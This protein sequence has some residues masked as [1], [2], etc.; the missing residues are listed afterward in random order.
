M[1]KNKS[2]NG[3]KKNSISK[4]FGSKSNIFNNNNSKTANFM[5]GKSLSKPFKNK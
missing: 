1:P 5:K 4:S 3:N 2:S